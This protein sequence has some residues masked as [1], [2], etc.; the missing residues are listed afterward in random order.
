MASAD[1]GIVTATGCLFPLAIIAVILA[2]TGIR[3]IYEYQRAIVFTLGKF[4]GILN[5]G[6]NFIIPVI[7]N[8]RVVDIRIKTVDIPKQEVM[9]KDNVPVSVNAV[10]YFKVCLLYTSPSP[11]D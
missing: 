10:V 5:P 8:T 4:S 3:I 2:L 1:L 11:R 6:L 9:T 7:Q